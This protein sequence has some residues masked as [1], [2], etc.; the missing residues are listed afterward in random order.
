MVPVEKVRNLTTKQTSNFTKSMSLSR[1]KA[2]TM[3]NPSNSQSTYGLSDDEDAR[4]ETNGTF[5]SK[6]KR[7]KSVADLSRLV[8]TT[9]W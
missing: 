6:I 9:N 5:K 8:K 1:T 7:S 2:S 3:Q 4:S